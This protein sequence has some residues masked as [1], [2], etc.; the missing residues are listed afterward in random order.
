ME[1]KVTKILK[2]ENRMYLL[3]ARQLVRKNPRQYIR[4]Q[5]PSFGGVD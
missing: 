2:E 4:R 1:T 3:K 5:F